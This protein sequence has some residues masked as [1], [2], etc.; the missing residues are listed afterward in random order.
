[1]ETNGNPPHRK[2]EKYIGNI[3]LRL[4][5]DK[6]DNLNE[7]VEL[8][9]KHLN[10]NQKEIAG[11]LSISEGNLS[12]WLS[13]SDEN[14]TKLPNYKKIQPLTDELKIEDE[15]VPIIG[16]KKIATKV[17]KLTNRAIALVLLCIVVTLL[18]Y[19]LYMSY[20]SKKK[21]DTYNPF[22]T[23][24]VIEQ[25]NSKYLEYCNANTKEC[26]E[27]DKNLPH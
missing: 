18:A 16:T 6:V 2:P 24:S 21:Y 5:G 4:P 1:M 13:N 15:S 8:A 10:V 12:K 9:K 25:R 20:E 26:A 7:I 3:K 22:V 19:I 17:S 14:Q 23:L 11:I 27:I